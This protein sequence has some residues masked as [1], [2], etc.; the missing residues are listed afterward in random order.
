MSEDRTQAPSRRRRQQAREAGRVAHSPDLTAAAGLLAAAVLLGVLGDDL[1][2]GLVDLIRAPLVADLP[3][4]VL[5]T[6]PAGAVAAMVREAVWS[7][8]MPLGGLLLGVAVAMLAVHQLQVGGLWVPA[9]L[10]PD[11]ARL[12]GGLSSGADPLAALG[13]GVWGILKAAVLIGAGAWVLGSNLPDCRRLAIQNPEAL[14]AACG[15]IACDLLR[16]LAL[17]VGALGV[18][19]FVLRWRRLEAQLRMTPDE[20]RQDR[21]EDDGDPALRARRRSLARTWRNDPTDLL[22]GASLVLTGPFGLTVLLA[23]GPPP[24][25][26]ITVRRVARGQD[27]TALRR[28]ATE[29]GLPIVDSPSLA[30]HFARGPAAAGPLPPELAAQLAAIWPRTAPDR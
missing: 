13:R 20:G 12:L 16:T 27:A 10:A 30:T 7:V 4:I 3:T 23:G 28:A 6:E 22:P 15:A 25:R 17:A 5:G 14:G 19:D 9:L 18:A 2:R 29:S 1:A 8:L 21:R 11:P 24:D 26:P